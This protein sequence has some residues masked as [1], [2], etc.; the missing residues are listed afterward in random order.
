[1]S[2]KSIKK[3]RYSL[4]VILLMVIFKSHS[5][6]AGPAEVCIQKG[7]FFTVTM[8]IGDEPAL[9]GLPDISVSTPVVELIV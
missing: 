1:M 9:K 3:K 8:E 6:G 7:H 2:I 5:A 4:F